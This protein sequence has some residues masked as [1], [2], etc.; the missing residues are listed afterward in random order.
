[1]IPGFIGEQSKVGA[2]WASVF[3]LASVATII[4][5]G[6]RASGTTEPTKGTGMEGAMVVDGAAL[7]EV[8]EDDAEADG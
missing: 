5:A 2:M 8:A 6:D 4:G 1:M 7:E 3:W